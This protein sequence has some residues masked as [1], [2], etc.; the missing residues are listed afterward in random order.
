[1]RWETAGFPTAES[2]FVPG[3]T[4]DGPGRMAGSTGN[5]CGSTGKMGYSTVTTRA[6]LT[7][8]VDS[9]CTRGMSSVTGQVEKSP[10]W[11]LFGDSPKVFVY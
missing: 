8:V 10:Q 9:F 4:A 5:T 7:F 11:Q 2:C 6:V 1:M 3:S